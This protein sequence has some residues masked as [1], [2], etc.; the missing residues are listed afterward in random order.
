MFSIVFLTRSERGNSAL[1]CASNRLKLLLYD[2]TNKLLGFTF[3]IY[4][5]SFNKKPEF[6]L[7]ER[8]VKIING[9]INKSRRLDS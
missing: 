9:N 3:K 1:D 2:G 8:L 6:T 7:V 4:Q 5:N